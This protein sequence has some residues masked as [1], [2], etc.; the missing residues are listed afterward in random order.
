MLPSKAIPFLLANDSNRWMAL[1]LN[2]YHLF[3]SKFDTSLS[4][5]RSLESR[6]NFEFTSFAL[7]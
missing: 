4:Q 6:S 1:V 5:R 7:I 3:Y 2:M